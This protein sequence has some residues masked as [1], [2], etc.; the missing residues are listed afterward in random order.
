MTD[1]NIL[2]ELRTNRV[3]TDMHFKTLYARHFA[4]TKSYILKNTGSLEDAEDIFQEA[5]L[6]VVDKM[7]NPEFELTCSPGTFIFA[8]TRNLWLNKLKEKKRLSVSMLSDNK[9]YVQIDEEESGLEGKISGWLRKITI[10]CQ[11]ILYS[12][13]YLKE[14]M[15][16]LASRMGWKNK[17]TADNQKYKCIQQLKK[18]S[19][20]ETKS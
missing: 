4:A 17:H 2:I 12:I 7:S 20:G 19:L 16:K 11:Q 10:R 3:E 15:I 1:N 8:V 6:V 13:F 14:P 5:M 18:A 9:E